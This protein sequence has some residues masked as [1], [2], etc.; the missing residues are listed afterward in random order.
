MPA[1]TEIRSG[2]GFVE[3][4]SAK[5]PRLCTASTSASCWRGENVIRL[6]VWPVP[7]YFT[8][9]GPVSRYAFIAMRSESGDSSSSSSPDPCAMKSIMRSSKYVVGV[10]FENSGDLGP[11]QPTM[12]PATSIRGPMSRSWA[13]ESRITTSGMSAP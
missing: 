7:P 3:C 12:L 11:P 5:S 9:L 1:S 10:A 13:I 2:S 4:V 8:K 6:F